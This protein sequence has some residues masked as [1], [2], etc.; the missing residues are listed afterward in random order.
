MSSRL[1]TKPASERTG[2]VGRLQNLVRDTMAEI[3]KV[4]WPDQETTRNLTLL[5]IA[6][7]TVLGLIL[8]GIDAAFVRIWE[9][10]PT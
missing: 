9:W 7:S 1:T 4:S 10:I 6:M 5:V 8:G 2:A 3:R